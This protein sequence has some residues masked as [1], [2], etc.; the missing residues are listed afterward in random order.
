MRHN[1][2]PFENVKKDSKIIL[3]GM[4]YVGRQYAAQ[5]G[6]GYCEILFGLDMYAELIQMKMPDFK[7]YWPN[8]MAEVDKDTYDAVVI[9][10]ENKDT[11]AAMKRNLLE[12]GVEEEKIIFNNKYYDDIK[13]LQSAEVR[14]WVKP[15]FSWYGE[16]LIVKGIFRAVGIDLPSYLDVGCNHPYEGNNTALLYLSGSRG[17]SIDANQKCIDLMNEER[18]DDV[19]LC[20]GVLSSSGDYDFQVI[21]ELSASNSFSKDYLNMYGETHSEEMQVRRV[22]KVH[23]ETLHDI[24]ANYCDH[25]FPDFFD[26]D[27]EGMDEDVMMSYDFSENGPKVICVETHAD[28]VISKMLA[29]GYVK[30]FATPHNFL[31]VR[32]DIFSRLVSQ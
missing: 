26:L 27:I 15:T 1:V 9:A 12:L 2:F 31:F 18:P 25:V 24:V 30:Y 5:A 21:D 13:T 16:D 14:G 11:A 7:M 29:E 6:G 4:G 17:I 8:H 10:V 32:K 28:E 3:Y 22:I 23:C 20:M 19:N